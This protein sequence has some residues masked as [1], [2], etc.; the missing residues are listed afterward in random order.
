MKLTVEQ[1]KIGQMENI[2][3]IANN[4]DIRMQFAHHTVQEKD[5]CK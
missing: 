2:T 5:D 4:T 3:E 1:E